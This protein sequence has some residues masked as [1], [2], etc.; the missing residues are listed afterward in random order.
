MA[1][2]A[3]AQHQPSGPFPI[4]AP[5]RLVILSEPAGARVVKDGSQALGS[6]PLI[7]TVQ[8]SGARGFAAPVMFEA[9]PADSTQCAQARVLDNRQI[10]PDTIEFFMRVCPSSPIRSDSVYA[11]TDVTDPPVRVSSPPV[12][13][14]ENLRRQAVEGQVVVEFVVDTTGRVERGSARVVRAS[15]PDF[16]PPALDVARGS[17]YLPGHLD[18][19]RVR[20]L[21]EMPIGFDIWRG[22]P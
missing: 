22:E 18:G 5:K 7:V 11:S 14:P 3:L 19:R 15:D 21:V 12:R 4:N 17:V 13:Y 20:V 8:R 9:L 2:P 1:K 10:T 6:T 16:G